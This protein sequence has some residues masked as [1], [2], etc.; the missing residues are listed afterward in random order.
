MVLQCAAERFMAIEAIDLTAGPLHDDQTMKKIDEENQRY[1]YQEF[2][3]PCSSSAA[4]YKVD[5]ILTNLAYIF[6]AVTCHKQLRTDGHTL[7]TRY[8]LVIHVESTTSNT[9]SG[10]SQEKREG[11]EWT[12]NRN[13][14]RCDA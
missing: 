7:N 13:F 3:R 6:D 11:E 4:K 14:P 10:S 12:A 1:D 5:H 2:N 8:L 9:A